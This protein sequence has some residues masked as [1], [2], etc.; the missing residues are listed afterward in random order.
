M[1]KWFVWLLLCVSR[2]FALDVHVKSKSA[3]LIN[4]D[5]GVVLFDKNKDQKAFPASITKIASALYAL[6]HTEDFDEMVFCPSECLVRICPK[7]KVNH[8]FTHPSHWLEY[9]GTTYGI[10]RGEVLPLGSLFYGMML[11]SGNDAANVIAHHVSGNVLKFTEDLNTYLEYIGCKDTQFKNP[12]GLHHPEHF[13]TAH[14]MARIA[15]EALK[16]PRFCQIVNTVTHE[17]PKTNKQNSRLIT[18]GNRLLKKVTKFYY[19]KAFG[20][21]SGY[22]SRAGY[23]LVAAAK[24]E[25]RT[26][27]AVLLGS[28]DPQQRYRDA[29][30][31]FEAA[32]AEKKE[33]RLLFLKDE[34]TFRHEFKKGQPPCIA[35]LKE[36]VELEYF[37]AE[38]RELRSF[39]HW[40]AIS[41]PI[42]EGDRV[43]EIVLTDKDEQVLLTAP[44]FA[45]NTLLAKHWLPQRI[46]L[47][48]ILILSLIALYFTPKIRKLLKR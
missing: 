3:I 48:F 11:I 29:I 19:S 35:G 26:L 46:L 8:N 17:R 45:Q 1:L 44:L 10:K 15:S 24:H 14:D 38:E 32:F 25:G 5:T 47:A 13:T 34:N 20:M 4:A 39:L 16:D 23:T 36:D 30:N 22:H 21:K 41:L 12:H 42:Q 18:Q 2:V 40:D 43:G 27:V 31:L 28:P 7:V 33:K 37:P 6:K 9:D